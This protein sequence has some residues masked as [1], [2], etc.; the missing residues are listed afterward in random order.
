MEY[1]RFGEEM[2][3]LRTR[4]HQTQKD[5]AEVLGV[6]KSF[7]SSVESGR[8]SIPKDW[9]DIICEHYH[10]KPY[11]RQVLED[12]AKASRNYIRI[13]LKGQPNYR[14]DLAVRFEDSFD[15][16]DEEISQRMMELMNKEENSKD[17]WHI[18]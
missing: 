10:L 9:I 7:L 2:R 15:R 17:E 5:M 12:A 1:T 11:P 4:R 13:A 14:R 16:I 8:R 18:D 3:V 6:T